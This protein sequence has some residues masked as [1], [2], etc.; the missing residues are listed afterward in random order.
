MLRY[1]DITG[2]QVDK[3]QAAVERLKAFEPEE[4]YYVAFSGGK[5][6]Q[7][8]YHLCVRAG[9]KF[10]AHYSV[11]SVDPP[12]LVRFIRTQ[13]P[14]VHFDIPHDKDGRPGVKKSRI[15]GILVALR[16]ERA[17]LE[18]QGKDIP[19]LIEKLR[20]ELEMIASKKTAI[21]QSIELLSSVEE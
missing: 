5:D 9:V 12:E 14:D 15:D 2:E 20:R 18:S 16:D 7:C 21:D 10:D 4:G 19:E 13:Y 3:V 11:T 1:I 17:F 6:S 8:V